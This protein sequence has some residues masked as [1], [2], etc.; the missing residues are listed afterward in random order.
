MPVAVLMLNNVLPSFVVPLWN[1]AVFR[2][3]V[4]GGSNRW[5][6]L[7]QESSASVGSDENGI[8]VALPDCVIG[9]M[10]SA[11]K[12][13]Q[14]F[15]EDRQVPIM[16]ESG[17]DNND[18]DKALQFLR[19]QTSQWESVVICG[20]LGGRFDQ[21]LAN[22]S[23]CL[24]NNSMPDSGISILIDERNIVIPL[25]PGRYQLSMSPR[26]GHC[27][28]VPLGPSIRVWTEG[29]EFDMDGTV[30]KMGEFISSS[31]RVSGSLV[32][33]AVKDGPFLWTASSSLQNNATV[34]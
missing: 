4:D 5:K 34:V 22:I 20:G 30:L 10:D 29:L 21:E 17:Q 12:D 9:D 14:S 19:R 33:I 18:L 13:V 28:I 3:C 6:L 15:L 31:N 26:E 1:K 24:A 32:S 8:S 16:K 7:M 25:P 11:M 23:T 27:G 2:V